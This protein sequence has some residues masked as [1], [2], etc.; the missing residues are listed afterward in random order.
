MAKRKPRRRAVEPDITA[1]TN[2]ALQHGEFERAGI[3]Y[4]RKAV[5]DS[6]K[7]RDV[8]TLR[9]WLAL[10]RYRDLFDQTER[11]PQRDS[12]DVGVGGGVT[13]G[14]SASLLRA[15]SARYDIERELGSLLAITEAVA[16]HDM[17]LSQWAIQQAGAK[18]RRVVVGG[19]LLAVYYEAK[20]TPL[21]IA[22]MD[23]RMAG[24][25]LAAKLTA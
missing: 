4:R 22:T 21:K 5:I 16:G 23:I 1:P 8:L 7:E 18:E 9:Q 2:E 19:K 17:T 12:C 25:W 20:T 10:G 15:L 6:L 3:A 24:D 11:S 13:D 14:P